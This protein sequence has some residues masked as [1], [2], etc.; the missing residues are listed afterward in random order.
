[1]S[2]EHIMKPQNKHDNSTGKN[3]DGK[4]SDNKSAV[5]LLVVDHLSIVKRQITYPGKPHQNS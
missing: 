1:M 2:T 4:N 5:L 3:A